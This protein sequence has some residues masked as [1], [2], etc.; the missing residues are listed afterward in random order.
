MWLIRR[1]AATRFLITPFKDRQVQG[2]VDA[3]STNADEWIVLRR[4]N[5]VGRAG[6]KSST[7]QEVTVATRA[8]SSVQTE[9]TVTLHL[10]AGPLGMN[11]PK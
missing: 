9:K 5:Y 8:E 2:V 4:S 6:S 3:E 7:G 10:I 1:Q 11:Q